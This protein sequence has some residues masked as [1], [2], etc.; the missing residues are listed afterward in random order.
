[1]LLCYVIG[2]VVALWC[3]GGGVRVVRVMFLPFGGYGSDSGVYWNCRG[4]V[5]VC[6]WVGAFGGSCGRSE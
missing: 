5:C 3:F 4:G 1:M 6:V 2:G